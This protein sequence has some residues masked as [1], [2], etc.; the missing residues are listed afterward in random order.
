M[1]FLVIGQ[2]GREHALIRALKFSASVSEVH[3]LPGGEGIS[4]DAICHPID[5]NDAKAVENFAKKYQFDCVLIGPEVPLVAGLSDQLRGL[6]MN[7]FGPSQIAAQLEG[8]K[9]FAKEFMVQAG[10]PT[11]KYQIVED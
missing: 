5:L 6:G 9:I 4:R 8:S 2:G 3:A 1:R 7:V 11:A 10:V